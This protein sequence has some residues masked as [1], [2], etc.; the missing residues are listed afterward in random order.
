MDELRREAAPLR[1]QVVELL[2][3]AIVAA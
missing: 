2:R 3:A 1:R